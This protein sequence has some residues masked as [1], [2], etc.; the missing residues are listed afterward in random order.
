[1]Y[2][3]MCYGLNVVQ[4]VSQWPSHMGDAENQQLF[5]LEARCLSSPIL[6]LKRGL[7]PVHVKNLRKAVLMSVKKSLSAATG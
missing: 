1:M 4:V 6:T 3:L 5:S 7:S 2:R